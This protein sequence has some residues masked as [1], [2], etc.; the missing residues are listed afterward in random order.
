MG[1]KVNTSNNGFIMPRQLTD[2]APKLVSKAGEIDPNPMLALRK[3]MQ[4]LRNP[5]GGCPWDVQQSFKT[6]A[7]YTIEE[8]YEVA[9]AIERDDFSN[10][11]EELGDLLL[12][13]VF[14]AQIAAESGLFD[15]DDVAN[16]VNEKMIRRHPHVFAGATVADA[17]EQTRRWN[18]LKKQ[19][20][21]QLAGS[22]SSILDSVARGLNAFERA[23]KLQARAAEIGFDWPN[24]GAV[25]EKLQEEKT[26]LAEACTS[27]DSDHIEE[28]LGDLLFVAVNI[29]RH[30]N[31]DPQA[32][33]RRCNLKFEQRFKQMEQL[34]AARG[35]DLTA[36]ALDAQDALW[37]EAKQLEKAAKHAGYK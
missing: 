35:L 6:I 24:V 1:A 4:R 28:E 34:A 37:L 8:A 2:T 27:L 22:P 10:L 13:V 11:R 31:V 32:A 30:T 25:L 3:I 36:L 7:P 26:E 15:F 23:K 29:A 12:Q 9:D 5:E 17:N 18:E 20:K 33:L 21:A 14:H 16:G 19:E